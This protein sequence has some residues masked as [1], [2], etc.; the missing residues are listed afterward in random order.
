MLAFPPAGDK[1][2]PQYPHSTFDT[3]KSYFP[4]FGPSTIRH[5][6]HEPLVGFQMTVWDRP[7]D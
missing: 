3:R 5:L 7:Q 6:F 1:T 2:A 4:P